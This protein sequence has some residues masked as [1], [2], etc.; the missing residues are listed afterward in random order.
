L[1]VDF[2]LSADWERVA[3]DVDIALGHRDGI[4][5]FMRHTGGDFAVRGQLFDHHQLLE[6]IL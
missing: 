6:R 1:R 4:V 2:S 5:D 3:D